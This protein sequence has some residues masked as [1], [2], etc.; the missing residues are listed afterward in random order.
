[1]PIAYCLFAAAFSFLYFSFGQP[2]DRHVDLYFLLLPPKE[3]NKEK[4]P[5]AENL[6]K[7]FVI[8]LKF[9]NSG[10]KSAFK[11]HKFFNG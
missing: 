7:I 9:M 2:K 1:L 5:L 11:H 4:S 8:I 3:S 10:A 6:L